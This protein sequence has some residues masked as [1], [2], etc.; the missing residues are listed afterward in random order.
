[1][2]PTNLKSVKLE[3]EVQSSMI[4][5][6]RFESSGTSSVGTLDVLFTSNAWYRYLQVP[7][8]VFTDLVESGSVGRAFNRMVKDV[9]TSEAL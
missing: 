5:K 3:A 7:I 9:Y 2:Q 4:K 6:I 1:M 8:L